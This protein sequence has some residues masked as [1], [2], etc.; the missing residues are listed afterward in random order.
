MQIFTIILESMS[1]GR[2]KKDLVKKHLCVFSLGALM[3]SIKPA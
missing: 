3:K 1:F 2:Y